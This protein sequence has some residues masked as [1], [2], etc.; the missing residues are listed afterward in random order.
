[1]ST[2]TYGTVRDAVADAPTPGAGLFYTRTGYG[3]KVPTRYRVRLSTDSPTGRLRRVYAMSYGNAAS[4]YVIVKG[5]DV[6]LDEA[7]LRAV[8]DRSA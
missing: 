5:E 7:E 8:L 3:P 4:L 2:L 1:M 6:F